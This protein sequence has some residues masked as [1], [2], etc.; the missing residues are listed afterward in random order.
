MTKLD[1]AA[2]LIDGSNM[3]HY[4]KGLGLKPK[5]KFDY[6]KFGEWLAGERT[7]TS[8]TYYIGKIRTD[9]TPKSQSLRANQQRLLAWLIQC[10]WELEFGHMLKNDDVFKEKGVDVHIAVDMLKGAYKDQYDT[11]ILVSSDNDLIPAIHE[12]K[13]ASK[14]IEYVGF[15]H[16]P[17]LGIIKHA[18]IRTLLKKEDIEQFQPK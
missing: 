13:E 6:K 7:I 8:A 10:G 17:S 14:Q 15:S 1:R 9:G 4:F 3:Y 18:N 12:V 16:Q 5:I 2:I 11:A